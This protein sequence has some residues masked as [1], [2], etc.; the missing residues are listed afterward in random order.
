MIRQLTD[1]DTKVV[2][3]FAYADPAIN[4]FLIG[5][6]ENF[7]IENED[8]TLWGHFENNQLI[9]VLLRYFKF[10]MIYYLSTE[11]DIQP[12]LEILKNY[13]GEILSISG[14]DVIIQNFRPYFTD[15]KLE[16]TQFCELKSKVLAEA[17]D[18][19]RLAAVEDVDTLFDLLSTIKEFSPPLK[20]TLTKTL[21]TSA[22]RI[23]MLTDETGKAISIA[24]TTAENSASAMI[25]GV[26]TLAEHR[27]KGYMRR[28]MT[29]LCA[30]LQSEGKALSLFY[31]N[32]NAGKIYHSMGFETTGEWTMLKFE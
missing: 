23:Y 28:V 4:T 3:D 7:G 6:I 9:G 17:D 8:M 30:D 1:A 12:F 5:D 20:E 11:T 16:K 25:I 26:C 14:K 18:A 27:M 32:P 10:F 31:S 21:E 22:G 19:I 2:L 24:Q 29:R 15:A 13:D